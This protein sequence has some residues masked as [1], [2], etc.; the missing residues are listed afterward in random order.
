MTVRASWLTD[1]GQTRE[2]TRLGLSGLLT[3]NA[4]AAE[5][6]P[7][8][9]R[10]GIVPGGFELSG[11]P[12]TMTFTIGVGRAFVQGGRLLQGVYPV[13]VTDT[14][15][16]TV[17]DGD[18]LYSRIDLVELAVKDDPYDSTHAT[19][20]VIRLVVGAPA[21]TPTV[22]NSP[23]GTAL[24][25]YRILVPAGAS[26]GTKPLDWTTA[27]TNLRYATAA[28]GGI[29]PASGFNGAYAGQYR[30]TPGTFQRWDGTTWVSYPKA[31]GGIAPAGAL[32]SGSYVGQYQENAAGLLQR[33]DGAAWQYAEGRS[34]ILLS[35][36]QSTMQSV[37]NNT[38]TQITLSTVDVDD[39]GGWSGPNAYTVSRTGWWRVTG[40][41]TW[42]GEPT[43]SRGARIAQNGSGVP[44]ATWLVG[45]GP[46]ATSVGGS[47]L[48]KCAAGDRLALYGM[49]NSGAALTTLGGSGYATSLT[50]EWLR[51]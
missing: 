51:S 12:G 4:G 19:E 2:D 46:G 34:K 11:G 8:K 32:T 22:P 13:V 14:E 21:A 40:S 25:L 37:A 18:A 7:L 5:N 36:E 35:V 24:P 39:V 31:V 10:G 9:G 29:V 27:V 26:A 45:A 43:G 28:L 38:W 17:P 16:F 15:T 20:A 30:D 47:V 49:Q 48:L 41:V 42:T 1:T 23:D 3:V 33:W 50:A 44:R 6:I